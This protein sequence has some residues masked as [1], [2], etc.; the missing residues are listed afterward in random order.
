M[1]KFNKVLIA[2]RGEIAVRVI[3]SLKTMGIESIAVYHEVDSES[4][5]VLQADHAVQIQGA[6]PVAAYL[7]MEGIV[8]ACK[9]SG[10]DAVHPG[11][12]F[13]SENASFCQRLTDEGIVFIGPGT[14]AITAMGDKI[15]SK[16]LA[17]KSGVN[18]IPGYTETLKDADEAVSISNGIG[19]PV[20]LKASAGGGGKGMRIAWN[21]DEAREGFER[22][23]REAASSFGDDRVFVEKYVERP[24]HIEIQVLADGEGNCVYLGERECSIQRRHQKVIEEAPSPFIDEETRK[25]MGEQ[26]VALAKAVDYVSAGTVEFI[27]DPGRHFYF[28]EMNT[29]LQVEHPVTEMIT[30]IDLV[31]KQVRIAEGESLGLTQKDVT[32]NGHAIECRIYAEDADADFVP[33]TGK[34]LAYSIPAGEGVRLD[35]GV[36]QDTEVTSAFDP[37]LAKLITYGDNRDEA[38]ARAQKA[39]RELVMLGVITNTDYL[40]RILAHPDF[41]SGDT[42]TSFL[43]EHVEI[44]K[45]EDTSEEQL[46][47]MLAAACLTDRV[48]MDRRHQAEIPLADMGEWRN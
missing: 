35:S 7:D 2:N 11:F 46:V 8:A 28:L 5:Y 22:A 39:L 26:A 21:A 41:A 37:M 3:R 13:L 15:T 6:T 24:R 23:S 38:L 36:A 9:S 32:L 18:V 34:I 16:L 17:E 19:Y 27:V 4:P 25:K 47:T 45:R 10:A 20:M 30:G 40:G 29:R 42:H 44:L 14:E 12:G 1:A 31:E 43:D 48:F 33:A